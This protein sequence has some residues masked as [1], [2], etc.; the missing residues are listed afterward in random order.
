MWQAQRNIIV[1]VSAGGWC[2]VNTVVSS[3]SS[4]AA[5][6]ETLMSGRDQEQEMKKEMVYATW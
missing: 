6:W 1:V 4:S 2:L 5:Q 3:G